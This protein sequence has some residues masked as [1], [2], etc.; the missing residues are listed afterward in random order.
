M[1]L[2]VI[3]F[4]SSESVCDCRISIPEGGEQKQN[5]QLLFTKSCKASIT[6]VQTYLCAILTIENKVISTET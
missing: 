3:Q 6:S 1:S 4:Q 2:V 5:S